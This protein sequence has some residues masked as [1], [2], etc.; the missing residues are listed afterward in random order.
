MIFSVFRSL[1]FPLITQ[2]YGLVFLLMLFLNDLEEFLEN[3]QERVDEN[4]R[5]VDKRGKSK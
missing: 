1:T 2:I 4:E 5:T 3:S